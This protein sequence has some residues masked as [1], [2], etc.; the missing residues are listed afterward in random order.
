M[1]VALPV[2]GPECCATLCTE[3]SG[4]V[5]IPGPQGPQGEP[6][7]QGEQGIQGI[8]GVK[9]DTGDTGAAGIQGVPGPAGSGGLS[10]DGSPEGIQVASPGQTYV[11]V[12][13]NGFWVKV[14]GVATAN[15][16]V[17]LLGP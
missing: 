14:T 6:G 13:V 1:A 9:G 5:A 2:P 3:T 11:D 10:G 7:E 15:G 8:Q 16:W 17:Q 12:L 4:G